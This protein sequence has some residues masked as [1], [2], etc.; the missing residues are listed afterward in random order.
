MQLEAIKPSH[1]ALALGC[2]SIHRFV[3]MHPLDVA[4]HQR[5]GVYDG[6][7][8][9]LAQE[10]GLKNQQ[11]M[12]RHLLYGDYLIERQDSHSELATRLEF[13]SDQFKTWEDIISYFELLGGQ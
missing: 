9:A 8:R 7:A 2:P 11:Q 6:N 3:Y 1:G 12:K 4:R 5:R 10:A 13:G